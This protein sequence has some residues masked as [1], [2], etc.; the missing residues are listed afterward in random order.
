MTSIWRNLYALAVWLVGTCAAWADVAPDG[1]YGHGHMWGGWGWGGMFL[2]PL[3]GLFFI[4][5]I[6]VAVVLVVRAISGGAGGAGRSGSRAM[7][8]LDERFARGEIDREEYEERRRAL[9]GD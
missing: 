5:A 4:A 9:T 2:G 3:F 6:A 8:I 7:Y 1:G